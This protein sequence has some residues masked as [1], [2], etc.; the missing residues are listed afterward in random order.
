MRW[1]LSAS[2][3]FVHVHYFARVDR[4]HSVGIDCHTKQ[5]RVGLEEESDYN[6]KLIFKY[7]DR[8]A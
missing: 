6:Y 2:L 7:V 3:S 4:E 8:K 5:P 1:H